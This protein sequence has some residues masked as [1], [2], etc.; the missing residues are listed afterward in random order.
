MAVMHIF[1]SRNYVIEVNRSDSEEATS[2]RG[3]IEWKH[4]LRS[5]WRYLESPFHAK[6]RG[7]NRNSYI[8]DS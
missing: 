8:L 2:N 4:D 3:N 5:E 6:M 1:R 7:M